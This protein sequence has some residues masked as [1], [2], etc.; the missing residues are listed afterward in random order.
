[1]P[2]ATSRKLDDSDTVLP[3]GAIASSKNMGLVANIPK[4]G[5][6]TPED[7]FNSDLAFKGKYAFAGNYNGFM[8]YDIRKPT[9]PQV[10]TQVLCPGLA[11]RHLGLEEPAGPQRRLQP[12]RRLVCQHVAAGHQRGGLGGRPGLR[13]LRPRGA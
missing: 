12:Q 6:F 9:R 8:V 5:A 13:H 1:M 10:V 4:Q 7:A 11:E 2:G 3:P